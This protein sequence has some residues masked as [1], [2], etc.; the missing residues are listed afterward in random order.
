MFWQNVHILLLRTVMEM[1]LLL[2]AHL[3]VS[4]CDAKLVVIMNAFISSPRAANKYLT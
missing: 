3:N 2:I 4:H 1:L